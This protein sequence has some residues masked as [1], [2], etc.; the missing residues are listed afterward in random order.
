MLSANTFHWS[1]II[2]INFNHSSIASSNH[3][4]ICKFSINEYD[5]SFTD[6][7]CIQALICQFPLTPC[8]DTCTYFALPRI[9]FDYLILFSFEIDLIPTM[10]FVLMLR[11][12]QLIHTGWVNLIQWTRAAWWF[13]QHR[14]EKLNANHFCCAILFAKFSVGS[15]SIYQN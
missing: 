4:K 13:L 6:H 1:L 2:I 8:T 12:K 15:E 3:N 11:R 7:I 5:T 14:K 9:K 10:Q